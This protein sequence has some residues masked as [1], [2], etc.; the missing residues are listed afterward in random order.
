[1]KLPL[2][3]SFIIGL[4]SIISTE[5]TSYF[6]SAN[7]IFKNVS[8]SLLDISVKKDPDNKIQTPYFNNL[9]IKDLLIMH[10]IQ[11][12]YQWFNNN[13]YSGEAT[14]LQAFM[15]SGGWTS[16]VNIR[17][18]AS[19]RDGSTNGLSQL[20]LE[21]DGDLSVNNFGNAARYL[22]LKAEA[23]NSSVQASGLPGYKEYM[24]WVKSEVL[25]GNQVAIGIIDDVAPYDLI[26]PVL[27]IETNFPAEDLVWYKCVIKQYFSDHNRHDDDMLYFDDHGLYSGNCAGKNSTLNCKFLLNND[28]PHGATNHAGCTPFIYGHSFANLTLDKTN[29]Q[30]QFHILIPHEGI[31]SENKNFGYSISAA[32]DP[33]KVTFPVHLQII[34]NGNP[35]HPIVGYNYEAPLIGDL[36]KLTFNEALPPPQNFKFLVS[37]KNLT[38]GEDYYLLR[39]EPKVKERPIFGSLEVPTFNFNKNHHKAASVL[40]F[41]AKKSFFKMTY[42]ATSDST[43]VFR[44]ISG[45]LYFISSQSVIKP[46]FV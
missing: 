29:N 7:Y 22:G 17:S 27:K 20:N 16:Q 13:G 24:T 25:K 6:E 21:D 11:P 35:W 37:V 46:L 23:F 26:V 45:F 28:I 31:G 9:A 8:A 5:S 2:L 30:R 4:A 44:C 39:F 32:L 34:D 19:P 15:N 38:I 42:N 14:L 18:I 3:L 12:F 36:E 10:L 41:T 33:Y 40:K 43:F 1:M